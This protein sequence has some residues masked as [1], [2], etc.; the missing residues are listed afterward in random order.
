MFLELQTP[1]GGREASLALGAVET[2]FPLNS[3]DIEKRTIL[4]EY[5]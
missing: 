4:Y 5:V 1:L 3:R 2:S